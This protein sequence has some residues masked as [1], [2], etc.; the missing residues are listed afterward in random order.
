MTTTLAKRLTVL[1]SCGIYARPGALLVN[2]IQKVAPNTT[3]TIRSDE[4]VGNGK[5]IINWFCLDGLCGKQ[6]LVEAR[7]P[8]AREVLEAI[9][10]L[11]NQGFR[12][13]EP[14]L[15][16]PPTHSEIIELQ[17]PEP[18]PPGKPPNAEEKGEG[19]VR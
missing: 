12:S 4:Y 17:D 18:S 15:P 8:E 9:P 1:N 6:V 19:S 3:V 14:C 10:L 16:I 11:F 5:S 7:G 13:K 2:T